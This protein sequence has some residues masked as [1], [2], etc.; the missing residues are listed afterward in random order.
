[1]LWMA[2]LAARRGRGLNRVPFSVLVCTRSVRPSRVAL[3]VH[4]GPGDDAEPVI[5]IM[6][7]ED[8]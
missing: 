3:I 6:R 4:I 2:S 1:M 8:D 5:T 7:P